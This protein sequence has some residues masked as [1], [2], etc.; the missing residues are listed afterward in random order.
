MDTKLQTCEK[1]F[2]CWLNLHRDSNNLRTTLTLPNISNTTY[3]QEEANTATC[4]PTVSSAIRWVACGKDNEIEKPDTDGPIIP[5]LV[6]AKY[7]QVVVTGSLHLVGT[8]MKFL[9]PNIC[10]I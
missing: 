1:N 9:G 5:R 10:E 4:F 3:S 6:N 8:V 2:K 7:I